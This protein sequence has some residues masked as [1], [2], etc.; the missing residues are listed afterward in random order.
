M[1]WGGHGEIVAQ[2]VCPV[3]NDINNEYSGTVTVLP[4]TGQPANREY[5]FE[6]SVPKGV[7]GLTAD[8][9]IKANEVRTLDKSRL[10]SLSPH[11]PPEGSFYD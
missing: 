4:I 2:P 8:S 3:A 1:D 6:V 7:A 9:H 10:V 5:P 11:L